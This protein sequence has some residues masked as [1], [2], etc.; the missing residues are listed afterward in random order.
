MRTFMFLLDDKRRLLK[1]YNITNFLTNEK[2]LTAFKS[3]LKNETKKA[4]FY[5]NRAGYISNKLTIFDNSTIKFY[6]IDDQF[7]YNY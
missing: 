6:S 7:M 2:E 5:F 1:Y 3:S 4:S